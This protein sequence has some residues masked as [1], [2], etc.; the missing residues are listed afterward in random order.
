MG[1]VY[2]VKLNEQNIVVKSRVYPNT[3]ADAIKHPPTDMIDVTDQMS[4]AE[5]ASFSKKIQKIVSK[6]NKFLYFIN[7]EF[8]VIDK[9]SF[10]DAM[11]LENLLEDANA[12]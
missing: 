2:Y 4:D 9:Y 3:T 8:H 10:N 7:G 5:K 11:K 1:N 12:N 6:P